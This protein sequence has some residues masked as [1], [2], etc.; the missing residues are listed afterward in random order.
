MR[1]RFLLI[2]AVALCV[3][4]PSVAGAASKPKPKPFAVREFTGPI[5]STTPQYP[6]ASSASALVGTRQCSASGTTTAKSKRQVCFGFESGN[7]GTFC[8]TTGGLTGVSGA[9]LP[10]NSYPLPGGTGTLN[11][12]LSSSSPDT[13]GGAPEITRLD[14]KVTVTATKVTGTVVFHQDQPSTGGRF[15]CDGSA[16]FSLTRQKAG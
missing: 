8:T 12:T 2:V 6:F 7:L 5:N 16:V 15:V 14:L 4:V 10:F 3:A 11:K 13:N 1:S 9:D